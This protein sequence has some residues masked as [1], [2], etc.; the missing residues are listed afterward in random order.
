MRNTLIALGLTLALLAPRAAFADGF[1]VIVHS[2]NPT[3]SLSRPQ[4][5]EYF[6]GKTTDWSHGAKIKPVDQV[7]SS[8][9]RQAFSDEVLGKSISAVK[10]YWQQQIFSG[11]GVPPTEVS[12]DSDVVAF[13]RSNPGAIGYVSSGADTSSVKVISIR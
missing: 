8:S 11:R 6:M 3:T 7:E 1:K 5:A 13:V 9:T 12:G 10:S 4:V 2:S